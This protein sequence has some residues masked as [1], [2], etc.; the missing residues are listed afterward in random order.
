[1][2]QDNV[3]EKGYAERLL[4]GEVIANL[5]KINQEDGRLAEIFQRAPGRN[6]RKKYADRDAIADDGS[7][8]SNDSAA[9]ANP[10]TVAEELVAAAYKAVLGRRP[11]PSGLHDYT[12]DF[13]GVSLAHWVEHTVR[14]LLHSKEFDSKWNRD[15]G[16]ISAAPSKPETTFFTPEQRRWVSSLTQNVDRI[17]VARFRAIPG[18]RPT[19]YLAH[20]SLLNVP[21]VKLSLDYIDDLVSRYALHQDYYQNSMEIFSTRDGQLFGIFQIGDHSEDLPGTLGY[22][23]IGENVTLL[24]DVHF[25]MS[26]G[27]FQ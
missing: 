11:D 24:P 7:A 20:S 12:K 19:L 23:G 3:G 18:S 17:V 5:K 9:V 22:V 26:K 25:W 15:T 21:R 2:V 1:L 27:L 6:S 14:S 8:A 4:S 10:A 16:K 13:R